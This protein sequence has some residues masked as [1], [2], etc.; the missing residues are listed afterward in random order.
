MAEAKTRYVIDTNVLVSAALFKQSVPARVFN[1][2]ARHSEILAS[3]TTLAELT[4]VM[5][6]EKFDKY[7][8]L[9]D[10]LS[11]L[12][13]FSKDAVTAKIEETIKICRDPR[14]DK[15]LE[16][17]V[18]GKATAI[19]TGDKDLLELHPFRNVAILTPTDFL[20]LHETNER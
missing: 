3:V 5:T 12:A 1:E 20:G 4:E 15:F 19:I 11:F 16:L 13:A 10:R 14:D 17:A 8:S 9:A 18:S 6:R 7:L 2:V